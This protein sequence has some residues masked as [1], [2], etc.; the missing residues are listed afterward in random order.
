MANN[1]KVI[2]A[3]E[4]NLKNISFE[5]PKNKFIVFSGVSGSG[6]STLAFDTLYKEGQRRY[7]ES[8]SSYARQFLGSFEKPKV[9]KIIGLSPSI[10][11]DQKTRSHNPRSTVGTVTEIYDYLRLLYAR[12][13]KPYDLKTNQEIKKYSVLDAQKETIKVLKDAK[14]KV[15]APIQVSGA[16]NLKKLY[17][18]YLTKGYL[19]VIIND[20]EYF[21]DQEIPNITKGSFSVVIDRIILTDDNYSRLYEAIENAYKLANGYANIISENIVLNFNEE[22]NFSSDLKKVIQE[23]RLFSFNTPLGACSHCNGLGYN[24]EIDI[25]LIINYN[26]PILDGGIIPYKNISDDSLLYQELNIVLKEHNIDAKKKIKD[27]TKEE[28]DILFYGSKK[29]LS[30]EMNSKSGKEYKKDKRFEGVVEM[31]NKRYYETQSDWIKDWLEQYTVVHTCPICHGAR[32]NND[33]L[34]FKINGLNIDELTS[35]SIS[36]CYQF[37]KELKLSDYNYKI[38]ELII[39]EIITRLEFLIDVGLDYLNLKR[40]AMTLSGGEAQRIRLATQI[41]SDLSGVLYVLDEPSIGLHQKDNDKLIATLKKIRDLGNTVVV[42]EHDEE[43]IQASDYILDIGPKAGIFGGD[44][45]YS[46]ETKDFEK[47]TNSLTSD[48]IYKRKTIPVPTNRRP[49]DFKN[50]IKIKNASENN[51]KN[52]SLDIPLGCMVLVTGVSGSGK[53]SLVN[54]VIL[55]NLSNQINKTNNQAGK[56]EMITTNKKIKKIVEIS[57]DPIGR[58]PRSNPAT[59]TGVFEEIRALYAKTQIAR[60]RGYDKGRF[61][62]NLKDGRCADCK[63]DGNKRITMHFL[64]DVYVKCETCHGMRYNQE[65]LDCKYKNKTISDALDMTISDAYEFFKEIPKIATTLKLLCDIGLGYLELGQIAPTLSGG[66]AQRIKLASELTKKIN[67]DTL[68]IL[69]EPTTGLHPYD[70]NKLISI[71]NKIVDQGASMLIIE[72]NLDMIKQA[73]YIIDLGPDGGD[74]GGTIV[75]TGRPEEVAKNLASYTGKYLKDLI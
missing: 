27:L 68:Y 69:D 5:L 23:P 57:Q 64:P 45:I 20:K 62:F 33:V 65:T 36:K 30:I 32:L 48:Y 29:L 67:N 15:L 63:G 54:E 7:I 71:L 74:N 43:T 46:G 21:L 59:Y 8:L 18:I 3:T 12:I 31:L 14:I 47:A 52:I 2:H 73:D 75:S 42:V 17:K 35:L 44:V 49:L 4:N 9:E 25:N 24:S 10:S 22:Y 53:S 26:K 61:S 55:K 19:R 50:V 1:I 13:A 70:I 39:H 58:T 40:S 28:F 41:G 60:E 66:E 34:M 72:H 38:S 16:L 37:F 51:L 56:V 11:I 6:K